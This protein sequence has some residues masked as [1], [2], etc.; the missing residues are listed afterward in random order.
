MFVFEI[1][2]CFMVVIVFAF[3]HKT[4]DGGPNPTTKHLEMSN[5]DNDINALLLKMSA[6]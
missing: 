5:I 1:F 3:E 4:H 6:Y 2:A